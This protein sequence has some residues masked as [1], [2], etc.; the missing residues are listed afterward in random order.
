MAQSLFAGMTNYSEQTIFDIKMDIEKWIEYCQEIKNLFRDTI[1]EL[2]AAKYWDAKV[3]FGF[4]VFCLNVGTVCDTFITDFRI[5]L[6]SIK[7]DNI[8]KREIDL[9]QNIYRVACEKE[10]ESWQSFK[11]Y[12]DGHWHEYGNPLFKKAEDLYGKGRDFFVTLRDVSNAAARMENYMKD[13]RK[14]NVSVN[15]NNNSPINIGGTQNVTDNSIHM[16]DNNKIKNANISTGNQKE[17]E[18]WLKKWWWA[19][20]VPIG[21]AVVAGIILYL[22]NMN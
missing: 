4:Q 5:I 19:F 1:D 7:D 17:K 12:D 16:G 8:T 14:M 9:M 13:D 20:V 3:P 11:N 18:S 22:L 6:S 10:D 15:G 2:K 21:V